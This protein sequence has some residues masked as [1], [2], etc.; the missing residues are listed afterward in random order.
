MHLAIL[1]VMALLS[2]GCATGDEGKRI[3]PDDVTWIEKERTTRAEVVARFGLPPFEF[4]QTSGF[5]TT[6][7][8]TTITTRDAEGHI[9]TIQTTT[10]IQRPTRL[11]KATY[12]YSRRDGA[13]RQST[14]SQFWVVYDER[15]VVQDYGF[16]GGPPIIRQ[17]VEVT[18]VRSSD[19][20]VERHQQSI[21]APQLTNNASEDE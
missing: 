11:R 19:A 6:S 7:T 20:A 12:A 18:G 17:A 9:K 13:H 21:A 15:G 5:T 14:Q 2:Y 10:Q 4:P 16:L 3:I 1:M 8:A